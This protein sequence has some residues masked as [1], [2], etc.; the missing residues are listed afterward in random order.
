MIW[1]PLRSPPSWSLVADTREPSPIRATLL[2]RRTGIVSH[3]WVLLSLLY[4]W[5]SSG[6]ID[7]TGTTAVLNGV[8]QILLFLKK[9]LSW[10]E[11]VLST[12]KTQTVSDRLSK[13]LAN[14]FHSGIRDNFKKVWRRKW[15]PMLL[16]IE[17]YKSSVSS[18]PLLIALVQ[19][20]E[21]YQMS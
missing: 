17:K 13:N 8:L 11:F 10:R 14:S 3:R 4:S 9:G 5:R 18:T 20:K 12:V 15:L 1:T 6:N 7:T 16:M 19:A 21:G 2:V